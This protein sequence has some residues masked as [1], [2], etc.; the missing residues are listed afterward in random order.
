MCYQKLV[1]RLTGIAF[2]LLLLAGCAAPK[3]TPS[4]P[5]AFPSPTQAV[6]QANTCSLND[7]SSQGVLRSID[8]GATWTSLGKACIHD[9][10]GLIPADPTPLLID[11]R[12]VLYFVDLGHL[13]QPVPQTIYRVSSTD[14][15]NFDKP[16]PAYTQTETMVDPFVL[17]LPN[18]SF[19]LYVPSGQSGMISAVSTDS[20]TFTLERGGDLSNLFGMPGLLLL[21][22]NKI[23]FFGNDYPDPRGIGSLISNDGLK[24]TSEGG[25]RIT[26]P[27]DYLNINNPEPIRLKDGS[28]LMLYQTQDKKHEGRPEW[29]AEIHLATST[30]GFNW[31]PNP[32]TISYGGTSCA[33]EAPDG[34]LY[35]YY[36]TQ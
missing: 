14:G 28:F 7:L 8:H 22:D 32:K 29:M 9:L 36:G 35:I 31:T 2:T 19:R 10:N 12:I 34:T 33:V 15:V 13:N 1:R 24:F 27:P 11:G 30:D 16:T 21:P 26:K 23:R 5:S 18:G 20:A 25:E 6:S 3:A 17:R 4:L